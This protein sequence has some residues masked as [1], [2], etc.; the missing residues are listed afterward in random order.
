[1]HCLCGRWSQVPNVYTL[2]RNLLLRVTQRPSH[3]SSSSTAMLGKLDKITEFQYQSSPWNLDIPTGNYLGRNQLGALGQVAFDAWYKI[4]PSFI[5]CSPINTY[6]IMLMYQT[7]IVTLF[8]ALASRGAV[9]TPSGGT[10]CKLSCHGHENKRKRLTLWK[11]TSN[12]DCNS[13]NTWQIFET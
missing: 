10:Q 13:C 8:F 6:S 11:G 9:A 4:S 7:L 12:A 1:M 5:S 2:W 3:W